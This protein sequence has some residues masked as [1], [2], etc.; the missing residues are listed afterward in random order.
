MTFS[1]NIASVRN[2]RKC[3]STNETE[4]SGARG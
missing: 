4:K 3:A 2:H 1:P